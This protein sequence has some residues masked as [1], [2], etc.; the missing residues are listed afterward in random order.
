MRALTPATLLAL[1]MILPASARAPQTPG[2]RT[3]SAGQRAPDF[4]LS[5]LG[6]GKPI[7]LSSYRGKVVL[8][9]FWATWCAP[10]QAEMPRFS[11]WQTRFGPPGLQV[12]GISMDDDAAPVRSFLRTHSPAYPIALGDAPLGERYGG[13]LSLPVTFLIDPE[14]RIDARFQGETNL[15]QMQSRIQFLLS[16]AA[17]RRR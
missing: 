6:S 11:A 17:S 1:T 12:L 3:L 16:A 8:L 7:H 14:G 10:C 13:I 5:A 4:T 2:G 9:N 15:D